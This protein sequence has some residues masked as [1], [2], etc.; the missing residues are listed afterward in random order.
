M[1]S[2]V[3]NELRQIGKAQ[4]D[5]IEYK[6]EVINEIKYE[7]KTCF[8]QSLRLDSVVADA[9]SKSRS[10]AQEHIFNGLVMLNYNVCQNNSE[11]IKEGDILSIRHYG[12]YLVSHVGG[13]S[14][15]GRIVV[16]ISKR[17]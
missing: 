12:K 8:I 5:L 2:F 17:I 16:E 10:E 9:I 1:S 13:K 15:S 14:K 3:K 4:I 7:T 11:S 6:N